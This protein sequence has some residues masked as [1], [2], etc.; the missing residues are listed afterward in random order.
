MWRAMD[1]NVGWLRGQPVHVGGQR[2]TAW[3]DGITALVVGHEN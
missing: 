3:P 2:G 1:S